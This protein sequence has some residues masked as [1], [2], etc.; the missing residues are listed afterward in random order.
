MARHQGARPTGAA[1]SADPSSFELGAEIAPIGR[2]RVLA[3]LMDLLKSAV[4]GS[5]ATCLVTGEPG[6]GK[7]RV[8]DELMAR[9]RVLD[10]HVLSGRAQ[11]Y[12]HG[13]AYSTLKDLLA[14]VSPD[15]LDH[16]GREALAAVLGAVDDAVLGDPSVTGGHDRAQRP[17][18]LTTNLLRTLCAA[19]PAVV[20]IDDAH[21]ADDESLTALCLA[22]RHLAALPLLLVF[23]ARRDKWAPGTGFAAAVGRLVEGS[24][25]TSVELTPLDAADVKAF[26]GTVLGGPPDDRLVSYVYAQSRGNPL[27]AR[28]T[29][30]SLRERAALRVEHGKHYLAGEPAPGIVSR[31]GALLHRVFQQDQDSRTLA[32]M[33]SAVKRVRL[34][35]LG[36]LTE[37]TGLCPDRLQRAFDALT[38]ASILARAGAGWYEFTHPLM[39]E[40]L[41]ED[42]GPAERRRVHR[43]ISESLSAERAPARMGVLEWATHV[44]EAASLGD[45]RGIEAALEAA[46][47]TRDAAPLSAATWYQRALDL[48]GPDAPAGAELLAR[49][50]VAYWKGSRPEFAIEAGTR[51]LAALPPGRL[52]SRTLACVANA[53]YAVGR[54]ADALELLTAG[55]PEVDQPA[56]FL[57]QKSLVLAHMGQAEQAIEHLARARAAI[58]GSPADDQAIAYTHLG[59][60]ESLIG[61]YGALSEAA[62]RLREIGTGDEARLPVGARLSALES[63]AYILSVAGALSA[64]RELLSLAEGLSSGTGWHDIG[65]QSVYARAKT[66]FLAGQWSAALETIRSGAVSLELAGLANNLAWL[67]LIEAEILV[68]QGEYA[69]ASDLLDACAAPPEWARYSSARECLRARIALARKNHAAALPALRRQRELGRQRRWVD[70]TH[71][72][73]ESLVQ[74]YLETGDVAAA[75]TAAGELAELATATGVPKIRHSADLAEAVVTGRPEPALQVIAA[76]D[77]D[78]QRF[79]AAKA[80]YLLGRAGHEPMEHLP[81]ALALF[82]DMS[83]AVW[84]KVVLSEARHRGLPLAR[85]RGAGNGT[86]M[87]TPTEEQLLRL[88]RDGLTNREISQVLHYSRKTVEAY[89]SRLYRKTGCNSRVELVVALERGKLS[90]T[91]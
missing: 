73:L 10:C 61:G 67:R 23:T 81:R 36:L 79:T 35:D 33:L 74:A 59:H 16:D 32:R 14:L 45:E 58:A 13:V 24:R 54:L 49:Q 84:Q 48:M 89:L 75:T 3:Q 65:G 47:V 34:D 11:D 18:V 1:P 12:D 60:A 31:R 42:L 44:T 68:E 85:S 69:E 56:A 91:R 38:E 80:H 21:L 2:E 64:A 6:I 72:A 76:A 39:A 70:T 51:A 71:A 50:T 82:E 83:A 43:A 46:T 63:G 53:T 66:Q 22:A 8:V 90:G 17:Y 27:F 41:Y 62:G 26:V 57:A 37:L 40:V 52:R 20:A 5:G 25:G 30:L 88:V 77:A 4:N 19:R 9:A 86:G 55:I 87:L 15:R 29:L 28:E 78:G 7:T